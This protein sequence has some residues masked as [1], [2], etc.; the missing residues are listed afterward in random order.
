VPTSEN[1]AA[2]AAFAVIFVVHDI[3][4]LVIDP[5]VVTLALHN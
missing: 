5:P 2:V 3:V 4:I 1:S